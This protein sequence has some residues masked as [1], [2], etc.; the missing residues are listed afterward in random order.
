MEGL[1]RIKVKGLADYLEQMSKPVFQ[2]GI[3]WRVVESKWPEIRQAFKGFDP[4]KVSHLSLAEINKLV[5]DPRVIR[6][7]R[8]IEAIVSNAANL[9]ALDRQFGSFKKYLR[10]FSTYDE[11]ALD[12][13]KQFKFLGQMGI[14]H[15]LWVV[16][17]DVPPWEE[18]SRQHE[19]SKAS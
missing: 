9:I 18:W 1:E 19:M 3:S 17:E 6:N 2:T 11:L 7:R 4:L 14:Y 13:H 8:K 15:F 10:S 16:G 5:A 12:L